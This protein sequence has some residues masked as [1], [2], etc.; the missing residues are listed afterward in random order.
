MSSP[1]AYRQP[2]QNQEGP[3]SHDTLTGIAPIEVR[4]RDQVL[5]GRVYRY[6]GDQVFIRESFITYNDSTRFIGSDFVRGTFEERNN[7]RGER[8]R[9]Q[10]GWEN[11]WPIFHQT[12]DINGKPIL[13]QTDWGI[14]PNY[15]MGVITP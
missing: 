7:E 13:V 9:V 10:T 1:E 5:G 2:Q 14:I 8:V 12:N 15:I 6:V 11:V 3:T 4:V